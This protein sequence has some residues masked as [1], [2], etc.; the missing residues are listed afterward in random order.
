MVHSDNVLFVSRI[1]FIVHSSLYMLFLVVS[2][3]FL[4]LLGLTCI[5]ML[6]KAWTVFIS[7][8]VHHYD[9]PRDWWRIFVLAIAVV[10]LVQ[11][12]AEELWE[13]WY[14]SQQKKASIIGI[15]IM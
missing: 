10:T 11:Q 8:P 6:F 14:S 7:A 3:R 1:A 12:V 4:I 2:V 9:L 15:I 13:Y 5:N